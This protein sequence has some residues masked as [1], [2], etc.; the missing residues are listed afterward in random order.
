MGLSSIDAL[1]SKYP[2]FAKAQIAEGLYKGVT[3]PVNTF[4][5][6]AVGTCKTKS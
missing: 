4:G 2:Y 1:I 3:S 5:V 6:K